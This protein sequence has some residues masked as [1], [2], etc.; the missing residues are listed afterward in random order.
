MTAN[1]VARLC[2]LLASNVWFA[3]L[4][5]N[6][7]RI[8]NVRFVRNLDI[9]GACQIWLVVSINDLQWFFEKV[10]LKAHPTG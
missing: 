3:P 9:S 10:R 7:S 8:A 6:I 4:A 5:T 1:G 2:A